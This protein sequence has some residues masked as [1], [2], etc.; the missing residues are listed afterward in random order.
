MNFKKI[1][2]NSLEVGTKLGFKGIFDFES[3]D[4]NEYIVQI[5]KDIARLKGA[6]SFS[7]PADTLT[8]SL[9][10]ISRLNNIFKYLQGDFHA[11]NF[12]QLYLQNKYTTPDNDVQ[13]QSAAQARGEPNPR[14]DLPICFRNEKG[15]VYGITI[16]YY[17]DD[18]NLSISEENRPRPFTVTIS[19]NSNLTPED[20]F[21][22]YISDTRLLT[23][24]TMALGQDLSGNRGN[25][26]LHEIATALASDDKSLSDDTKKLM[27]LLGRVIVNDRL[28]M[29]GFH[30]L[31]ARL[32]EGGGNIDNRD[33]KKKQFDALVAQLNKKFPNNTI[34][35]YYENLS[36]TDVDFF[37]D[38]MFENHCINVQTNAQIDDRI[39]ASNN[40]SSKLLSS[41]LEQANNSADETS[42]YK[43][44]SNVLKNLKPILDKDRSPNNQEKLTLVE[45]IKIDTIARCISGLLK[46]PKDNALIKELDDVSKTLPNQGSPLWQALGAALIA[47]TAIALIVAGVVGA[48]PTGGASLLA[49]AAGAAVLTGTGAAGIVKGSP[50]DICKSLGLFKQA[51]VKVSGNAGENKDEEKKESGPKHV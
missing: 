24:E 21:V 34:S 22:T 27:T 43:N 23:K 42:F 48:I 16:H 28:S 13:L 6:I 17:R 39:D 31:Y 15:V 37:K 32:L 46:N 44:A 38:G 7:S 45:L 12:P 33:E 26:V 41:K 51:A 10:D 5:E 11:G 30:E 20:K 49:T 8:A 2:G 1:T 3:S 29:T 40:K 47:F 18:S 14:K 35:A 4:E 19:K 9:R 25:K 50:S 36:L